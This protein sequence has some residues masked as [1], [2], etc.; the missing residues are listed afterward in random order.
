[1][2][3]KFLCKD[4]S[5]TN[6]LSL[7]PGGGFN[8]SLLYLVVYE[9]LHSLDEDL[10]EDGVSMLALQ[11]GVNDFSALDPFLVDENTILILDCVGVDLYG[12]FFLV[13]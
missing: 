4:E 13:S 9:L 2:K 8:C 11:K 10:V 1:M 3:D 5:R 12:L 6:E 7:E